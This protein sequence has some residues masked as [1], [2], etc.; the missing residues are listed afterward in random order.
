VGSRAKTRRLG[1]FFYVGKSSWIPFPPGGERGYTGLLRLKPHGGPLGGNGAGHEVALAFTAT[2]LR[3]TRRPPRP[4]RSEKSKESRDRESGHLPE[5]RDGG[6]KAPTPA[7][8]ATLR[9]HRAT[10]PRRG[11]CV[12]WKSGAPAPGPLHDP[13]CPIFRF[14]P[15]LPKGKG[16]RHRRRTGP[17]NYT[18]PGRRETWRPPRPRLPA[19][20]PGRTDNHS[21]CHCRTLPGPPLLLLNSESPRPPKPSLLDRGGEELPKHLS[22]DAQQAPSDCRSTCVQCWEGNRAAPRLEG[23]NMGDGRRGRS[24]PRAGPLSQAV[25]GPP[26]GS[27]PSSPV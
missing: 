22:R 10:P 7:L 21:E 12:Q 26:T 8:M 25:V 6:P 24:N 27:S 14:L 5:G 9:D 13:L 11:S 15:P 19:A 3:G 1:I 17:S 4:L 2:R 20:F 16:G 18:S 23:R